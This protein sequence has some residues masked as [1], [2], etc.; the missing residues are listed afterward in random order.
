MLEIK[1]SSDVIALEPYKKGV[2]TETSMPEELASAAINSMNYFMLRLA[3]LNLGIITTQDFTESVSEEIDCFMELLAIEIEQKTDLSVV[4]DI[5]TAEIIEDSYISNP[6]LT[7]Y[8]LNYE[9]KDVANFYAAI[10]N[11]A[12][13]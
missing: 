3:K 9:N 10:L 8:I 11:M 2:K 4:E 12:K 13:L 1:L 6:D 5:F 7:D